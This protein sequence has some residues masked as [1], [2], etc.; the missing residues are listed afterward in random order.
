MQI[1]TS[2]ITV[3]LYAGFQ[4]NSRYKQKSTKGFFH[5]HICIDSY[6]KASLWD[7]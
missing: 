4:I 6:V 2:F 7:L 5:M 3:V 1:V